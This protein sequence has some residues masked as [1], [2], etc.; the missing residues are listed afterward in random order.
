MTAVPLAH[1]RSFRDETDHEGRARSDLLAA[2]LPRAMALSEALL[3]LERAVDACAALRSRLGSV[4]FQNNMIHVESKLDALALDGVAE[5]PGERGGDRSGALLRLMIAQAAGERPAP[6]ELRLATQALDAFRHGL[7][8]V[9]A[10]GRAAL[11]GNLLAEMVRLLRGAPAAAG[12]G[13][14]GGAHGA[15]IG[16]VHP[17]VPPEEGLDQAMADLERFLTDPP[18]LPLAVRMAMAAARIELLAPFEE[19]SAQ[20]SQLLMPLMAVAD[21][22]PPLFVSQ[23]LSS[24][25]DA[26]RTALARLEAGHNWEGWIGQYLGWLVEAAEAAT[27]RLERAERLRLDREAG[28]ESL[29][30]DSTARRLAELAFGM[31]VLTVGDAQE[32][33]EVSFQTANAAVATLVRLGI[34]APHSNIRRNRIFIFGQ[35][36][37][38]LTES[39]NRT[40]SA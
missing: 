38:M 32:M 27:V 8:A 1:H 29:R 35:T 40:P 15:R 2:R 34:L 16:L 25:R 26:Y 23:V 9:R 17:A 30:S 12:P 21:G 3:P 7:S 19:A 28:M 18:P 6:R 33:L 20:L 14:A 37:D 5:R 39:V 24:R 22:R 13:T 4:P 11:G 10:G 31:P 36:L